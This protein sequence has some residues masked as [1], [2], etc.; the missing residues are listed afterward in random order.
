MSSNVSDT[1]FLPVTAYGK[2]SGREAVIPFMA[3]E[4]HAD[5]ERHHIFEC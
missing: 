4:I 5:L 2:A 3:R 1:G